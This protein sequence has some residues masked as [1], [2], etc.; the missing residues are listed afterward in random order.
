[1]SQIHADDQ[2]RYFKATFDGKINPMDAVA[3]SMY[4]RVWPRS[5]TAWK[6]IKLQ[7]DG[8]QNQGVTEVDWS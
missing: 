8:A 4:K 7:D 5:A 3:L 1:M 2:I 6:P